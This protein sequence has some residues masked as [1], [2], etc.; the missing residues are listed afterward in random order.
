MTRNGG[1]LSAWEKW[2]AGFITDSQVHCLSATAA[3]TRWIAPS[4]VKTKEKKVDCYSTISDQRDNH[5]I[6]TPS[7]PLL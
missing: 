1:D 5:R 7:R 3:N 2:M 6:H 4:S